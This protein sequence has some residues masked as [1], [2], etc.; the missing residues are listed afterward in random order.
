MGAVAIDPRRDLDDRVVG[1]AGERAVVADVRRPGRRRGRR[2]ARRSAGRRPRCRTPRRGWSRSSGFSSSVGSRYIVE[3]L[4]LD[5]HDLLGRAWRGRPRCSA[6]TVLEQVVVAEVVGRDRPRAPARTPAG[7]PT[8][9]AIA[10]PSCVEELRQ[11]VDAVDAD[12]PD[13]TS[14]GSA[15]RARARPA[16][17]RRRSAR[18]T[19]AGSRS[20]RCTARSPGGRRRA[21]PG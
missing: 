12:R 4:A 21:A 17:A 18:R 8:S 2:G 15:R 9:S 5:L 10:S 11:A 7:T 14:G 13:P 19:G 6:S 20:R 16:R 3:Q 1:Q